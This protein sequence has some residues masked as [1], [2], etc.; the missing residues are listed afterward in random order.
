MIGVHAV[1]AI[2]HVGEGPVYGGKLVTVHGVAWVC[3]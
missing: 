1:S 2:L 3:T